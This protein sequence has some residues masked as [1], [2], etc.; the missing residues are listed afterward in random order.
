MS[1]Q[2]SRG[3]TTRC[4]TQSSGIQAHVRGW[5]CGVRV[6]GFVGEDGLDRFRVYETSGSGGSGV[7]KFLGIVVEGEGFEASPSTIARPTEQSDRH[8]RHQENLSGVH[9]AGPQEYARGLEERR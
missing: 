8:Q 6:E 7:E 1:A 9:G 3:E 2:G 5:N 4:G